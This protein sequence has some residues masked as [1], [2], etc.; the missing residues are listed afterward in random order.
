MTK[1]DLYKEL[2]TEYAAPK[3]PVLVKTRPAQFLTIDG[4][5]KPGDETFQARLG[6]LYNIAYTIKMTKKFAGEQD[7]KVCGLEG[8]YWDKPGGG[9]TWKLIIRTPDFVKKADLKQAA[10]KLREK[11]KPAEVSE[12]QLEKIKEGEC[13]QMLHVGPYDQEQPTIDEMKRFAESQGKSCQAPHHE[14]YISDPRR[15]KPEK[16]RTILRYP[17]K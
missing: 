9:W 4:D 16:L 6:A 11:G 1:L 5:S 8:L 7:Y 3:K 12:V 15:V 17:V 2:K 13:V 14:I 10:A